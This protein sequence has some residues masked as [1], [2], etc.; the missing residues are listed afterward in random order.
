MQSPL[1]PLLL[2][3][4][5]TAHAATTRLD[6]PDRQQPAWAL[7]DA[8]DRPETLVIG[9]PDRTGRAEITTLSKTTP[10]AYRY[11][12]WQVGRA[13]AG[14]GNVYYPLKARSDAPGGTNDALHFLNGGLTANPALELTPLLVGATLNGQARTCRWLPGTR[15]MGVTDRRSVLITQDAR[16]RLTYQTFDF[17]RFSTQGVRSVPGDGAARTS[18]PSLTVPGG[19]GGTG[20]YTFT[21]AGYTYRVRVSGGHATLSVQQGARTVQTETFRAFTVGSAPRR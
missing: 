2:L 14:A 16:G 7:C 6:L 17:A 21:N 9:T 1:L 5:G 19:T 8:L 13:D 4:L 3:A 20:T 18:T 12:A 15:F 10:G 11:A